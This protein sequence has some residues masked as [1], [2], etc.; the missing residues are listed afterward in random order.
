[1]THGKAAPN[2]VI[3]SKGKAPEEDPKE[4]K[5][6]KSIAGSE[7]AVRVLVVIARR[8]SKVA[9]ASGEGRDEPSV[10]AFVVVGVRSR[11]T[12]LEGWTLGNKRSKS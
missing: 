11:S 1:V 6:A 8:L 5:I 10:P 7:P 3:K 12:S 4:L 9:P 2:T